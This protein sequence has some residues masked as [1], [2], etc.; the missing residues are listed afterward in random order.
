MYPLSK[1]IIVIV[2]LVC[3]F[4]DIG[5]TLLFAGSIKIIQTTDFMNDTIDERCDTIDERDLGTLF[6]MA[7]FIVF[8]AQFAGRHIILTLFQFVFKLT[9]AAFLFLV[10]TI[11]EP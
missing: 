7:S 6:E 8:Q 3:K 9:I 11:K 5:E 10:Q 1:N 4:T 2:D